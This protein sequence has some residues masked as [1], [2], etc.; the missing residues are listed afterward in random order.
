MDA[1]DHEVIFK[2]LE[3]ISAYDWTIKHGYTIADEALR[4][5]DITS[6][7]HIRVLFI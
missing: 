1:F 2:A 4:I 6:G 5:I 7:Q 3:N